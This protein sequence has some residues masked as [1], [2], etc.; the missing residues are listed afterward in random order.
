MCR[1]YRRGGRITVKTTIKVNTKGE[2]RNEGNERW[3]QGSPGVAEHN[4]VA[5]SSD[6]CELVKGGKDEHCCLAHAFVSHTL[7]ENKRRQTKEM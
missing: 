7:K 6:G 5:L 4:Y 2:E 1:K 3:S